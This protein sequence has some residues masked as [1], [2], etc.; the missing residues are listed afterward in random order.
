M[1]ATCQSVW[2]LGLNTFGWHQAL[3]EVPPS[4]YQAEQRVVGAVLLQ[5][6]ILDDLLAKVRPEDFYFAECGERFRAAVDLRVENRP[7]TVATVARKASHEESE[8]AAS[9]EGALVDEADFWAE[10]VKGLARMRLLLEVGNEAKALAYSDPVEADGA[11]SRVADLLSRGSDSGEANVVSSDLAGA[12]ALD[13]LH[14]ALA[15]GGRVLGVA[16]GWDW[17]DR[18]LDGLTPGAVSSIYGPTSQFKSVTVQNI[19]W[20]LGGQ[21]TPVLMFSTE[22]THRQVAR[23]IVALEAGLNI[24]WLRKSGHLAEHWDT[25]GEATA[26]VREMPIWY[27]DRSILNVQFVKE[28]TS[29]MARRE[30][31]KVVIIDLLDHVFS[32]RYRDSE[33]KNE[34][35]VMQQLKDLAKITDTHI[36]ATAHIDKGDFDDRK[37]RLPYLA[38]SRIKGSAAKAQDADNAISV[39]MVDWDRTAMP[40]KLHSLDHEERVAAIKSGEVFLLLAI[41][42]NREGELTNIPFRVLLDEGSRMQPYGDGLDNHF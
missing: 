19:A 13:D 4:D 24:N 27:N 5:P 10:R 8:V 30:G 11:F 16:T 28:L 32:N 15:G 3:A 35:F 23:R 12:A 17:F 40:P 14:R 26:S 21:G 42:K 9:L 1:L 31:V 7:V 34:A 6:D 25:I 22:M 29:H 41:T 20:R 18:V 36:I 2:R 33:T 38:L 37:S 39:M